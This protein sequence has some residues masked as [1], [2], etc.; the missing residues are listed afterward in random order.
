MKVFCYRNL[1]K[2]GNVWSVRDEA[3]KLVVDHVESILLKDVTLKVSEAGRQ[4]VLKEKRKNVHAGVQGERIFHL[5]DK[6][7]LPWQ[8]VY[9]NPYKNDTFIDRFGNPMFKC[10]YARKVGDQLMVVL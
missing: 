10:K 5:Q 9:Y 6:D 8:P 2:K 1:H 4:R 7:D 3:T